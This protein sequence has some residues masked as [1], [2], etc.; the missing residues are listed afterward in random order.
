MEERRSLNW[1]ADFAM[2]HAVTGMWD[3]TKRFGEIV[4]GIEDPRK[5]LHDEIFLLAPL[6]D[7]EMWNVNVSSTGSR[8][9]LIHVGARFKGDCQSR[10]IQDSGYVNKYPGSSELDADVKDP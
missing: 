7:G 1:G 6:L 3:P 5:M 4:T 9:F 8:M 10:G 2:S